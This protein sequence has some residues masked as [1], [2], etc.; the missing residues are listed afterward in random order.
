MKRV[1]TNDLDDRKVCT[2]MEILK[3]TRDK[4]NEVIDVINNTEFTGLKHYN[5]MFKIGTQ[6]VVCFDLYSYV[7]VDSDTFES[8]LENY[9]EDFYCA[10]NGIY[11]YN[12]ADHSVVNLKYIAETGTLTIYYIDSSNRYYTAHIVDIEDITNSSITFKEVI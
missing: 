9:Q 8:L 6:L 10:C 4:L 1:T 3:Q 11:H 2:Y 12:N 5:V 7:E